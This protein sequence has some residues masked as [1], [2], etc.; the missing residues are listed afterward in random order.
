MVFCLASPHGVLY[1]PSFDLAH[2]YLFAVAMG[3][4]E[5]LRHWARTGRAGSICLLGSQAGALNRRGGVPTFVG[6]LVYGPPLVTSPLLPPCVPQHAHSQRQ[7]IL[8]TYK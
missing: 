5:A 2:A 8:V 7:L 1:K 3:R 6:D 4:R